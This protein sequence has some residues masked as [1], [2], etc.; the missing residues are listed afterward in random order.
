MCDQQSLRSACAYT[1]PDQ[2]LCY[3]FEYSMTV[4]L[5]TEQHLEFLSLKGGCK[6]CTSLHLSKCHI[7]GNYMSLLIFMV[8]YFINSSES[9]ESFLFLINSKSQSNLIKE[10]G[11][12][13]N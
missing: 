12:I 3:L 2:R 1:Q 7:V 11:W 13:Y 8:I 5:L 6:A 9:P 10:L 4:N